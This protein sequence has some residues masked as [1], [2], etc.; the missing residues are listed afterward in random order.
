MLD[1][2]LGLALNHMEQ[3][4]VLMLYLGFQLCCVVLFHIVVVIESG[5]GQLII[6]LA[7]CVVISIVRIAPERLAL[8]GQM[9][10][11][12][13]AGLDQGGFAPVDL[14]LMVPLVVRRVQV[15]RGHNK[16]LLGNVR[17]KDSVLV[18]V[19]GVGDG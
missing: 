17:V 16:L 14:R 8:V 2:V 15:A 7:R 19:V 1:R 12:V 3:V 10:C 9:V 4:I 13:G 11:E 6:D 18:V 5:M